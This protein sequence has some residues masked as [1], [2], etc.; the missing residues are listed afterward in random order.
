[1]DYFND[2]NGDPYYD[3]DAS[4]ARYSTAGVDSWFADNGSNTTMQGLDFYIDGQ[5]DTDVF[6]AVTRILY[7]CRYDGTKIIPDSANNIYQM[8][9]DISHENVGNSCDQVADGYTGMM[10]IVDGGSIERFTDGTLWFAA[11]NGEYATFSMP[12]YYDVP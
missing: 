10:T 2:D 4:E 1:M 7:G 3:R 5:A 12:V 9:F 8:N 11:T 6:Y